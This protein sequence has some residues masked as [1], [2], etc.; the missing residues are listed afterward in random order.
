MFK[1]NLKNTQFRYTEGWV[2][3]DFPNTYNQAKLLE[4]ELSGFRP[5]DE[6]EL[7]DLEKKL[8]SASLIVKPSEITQIPRKILNGGTDFCFYLNISK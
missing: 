6:I 2:L 7:T 3:I 8:E 1:E 5:Q 4:K